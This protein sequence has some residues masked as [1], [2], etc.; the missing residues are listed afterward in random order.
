MS[1][2][3][4]LILSFLLTV[5]LT[6][7]VKKIAPL[8]GLIDE[9][10]DARKIHKKAMPL[11]G[12]LAIFLSFFTILFFAKDIL[13]VGDLE[14]NHWLGFF[15]G[16]VILIIGGLLD[17]K[18]NLKPKI[19]IIFPLIAI[20]LVLVSGIN[21]EKL[22]NPFGGDFIFLNQFEI[23][24]YSINDSLVYFLP[25]SA[26]LLFFWL[27][28]MMYTTKL[29]DGLDGLVTG[30]TMI[31]SFI[32]FLFTS[33]DKYSQPDIAL[34][35]LVLAG[36]CLGF[37]I[38]N[39]HPAS[40][41]LGEGGSLFLG[42]ALGVLAI[43]SGGKIAIALLVMGIPIIDVAWTIIRRIKNGKNP[44][45]FSDR[46]HLHYKILDT[47][48]SQEKTVLFYY[49]LSLI[50]GSSALFLQSRGKFLALISLLVLMFILIFFFYK[51][52]QKNT[53]NNL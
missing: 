7:I 10:G 25:I 2:L 44:F 4:A 9:P 1:L 8:A 51:K 16:G 41:F 39:W 34:A 32:I 40:I 24:M 23:P 52:N 3:S 19:Q 29:L 33:S 27:M 49:L 38:F 15:A 5:A 17:D 31:G 6:F 28:G 37:L 12:G 42:Y 26:I 43:I 13:L 11:G 53:F 14:S 47:G 45:K 22:S 46:N 21:I 30:V 20:I 48:I 35:S 36:A 18:F 50:F